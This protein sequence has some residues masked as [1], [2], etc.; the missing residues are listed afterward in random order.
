[1]SRMARESYVDTVKKLL[2]GP[3]EGADEEI[4]SRPSSLYTTGMLWSKSCRLDKSRQENALCEEEVDSVPDR[5][6]NSLEEKD[7]GIA[8]Y[9]TSMPCCIGISF[10]AKKDNSIVISLGSTARYEPQTGSD[11]EGSQKNETWKRAPL[12]I[13]V[14]V[15]FTGEM[16]FNLED[17]K[18]PAGVRIHC[19]ARQPDSSGVVLWT[20]TLVNVSATVETRQDLSLLFQAQ[21]VI[22]CLDAND[23]ATP[24]CPIE[25]VRRDFGGLEALS[26]EFTFRRRR[27]FA[28]G[29]GIAAQWDSASLEDPCVIET[30]WMPCHEILQMDSS[31]HPDLGKLGTAES[32]NPLSAEF[33][34]KGSRDLVIGALKNL[35]ETYS[36]WIEGKKSEQFSDEERQVYGEA[37]KGNIAACEYAAGRI[38]DGI[39]CLDSNPDALQAFRWAN[40][41]MNAQSL[42]KAKSQPRPLEWRPF[43]LAFI[44][45]VIRGLVEPAHESRN[46][47]DLLWFPTGG[48]KTEAYLGLV[49]F[50]LFHRRLVRNGQPSG[51]CDV[52]MRYTLRLLTVQQFQRACSLICACETVRRANV[53]RLGQMRYSVGLFV[54]ADSTPNRFNDNYFQG[55]KVDA[56]WL[57]RQSFTDCNFNGPTP[58]QIL[59]CPCCGEKLLGSSYKIN[60]IEKKFLVHCVNKECDWS[61]SKSE[62]G[63]P[64]MTIDE[65]LYIEP[66]SLLIGTVDKFAQLPTD[67]KFRPLFGLDNPE[68]ERPALIIQ[69]ELHLISGQLGSIAGLYEVALDLLCTREN[70]QPKVIGST[71]TIGQAVQQVKALY[72]RKVMQFPPQGTDAD[73]SFFA[74]LD[75][76]APG[77]IYLGLSTL[78]ARSPKYFLQALMASCLHS[79]NYI[80]RNLDFNEDDVDPYW[81]N[82]VYFNSMRELGSASVMVMD[83]VPKAIH[84]FNE[85]IRCNPGR[86]T[87]QPAE[88]LS[89]NK[90]SAELP[91]TLEKL[92]RRIGDG[93]GVV[94]TLLATNMLSVGVDIKRLGSMIV[95][96]QPKTTAE[97]IQCTSRV[98]RGVPGVVFM[99]YNAGKPRDISHFEHF[100]GY[101]ASI[102]KHV[103]AVSVT[104]FA[105]RA[106]DKSLHAAVY[107]VFRHLVAGLADSPSGFTTDSDMVERIADLLFAR[108][109]NS[110][111]HEEY[112]EVRAQV[113]DL[114]KKWAERAETQSRNNK[115]LNYYSGRNVAGSTLMCK[116]EDGGPDL[117]S[118]PTQS[119]M[120]G[121]EP[122]SWFQLK[123]IND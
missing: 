17:E 7:P 72:G 70:H 101:H 59:K 69:D 33:L 115:E 100:V 76:E 120:R 32:G 77:R 28:V 13:E 1:M 87:A 11:G 99:L 90:S 89:S 46:D 116:A 71:A 66:P 21:L 19:K 30:S 98:G 121:V 106:L 92:E 64:F 118:K 37:I 38:S 105:P 22:G 67:T 4:G 108:L 57:T 61:E 49:A 84:V 36:G 31:G 27:V 114:M 53:V 14:R 24:F 50:Q 20:V 103:E 117:G 86:N 5:K 123:R 80:R 29:H 8:G 2:L 75:R 43:Q 96:G 78:G 113:L 82:V 83:D 15:G 60:S 62:N 63:L 10:R 16:S 23:V 25:P 6:Q 39:A 97:T 18:L 48:G 40:E 12:Q 94:D 73:D 26:S 52:I 110:C 56:D 102:Y 55:K 85:R 107:A 91:E 65:Q 88:E 68:N 119:S 95:N 54:G 44:L 104:P 58:K 111:E 51:C 34:S 81:T 42:F 93:A 41:A 74:V 3:L 109:A 47:M 122:T 79:S 35:L 112:T 9:K 45:A